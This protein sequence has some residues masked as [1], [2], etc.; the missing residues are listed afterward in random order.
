M[1]N[2]N[3]PAVHVFDAYETA[4]LYSQNDRAYLL[5]C[6]LNFHCNTAGPI[7]SNPARAAK[8]FRGLVR[9]VPKANTLYSSVEHN[10][11]SNHFENRQSRL[12]CYFRSSQKAIAAAAATFRESMPSAMG[13]RTIWSIPERVDCVSP[14]SSV[15]RK[16]AALSSP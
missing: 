8:H 9:A 10:M 3:C 11:S 16:T 14:V 4:A 15:P 5:F 1:V 6:S 12:L 7:V 2:R 13:M